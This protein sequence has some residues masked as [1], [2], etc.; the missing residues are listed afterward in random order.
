M[1]IGVYGG[2]GEG[3]D[4]FA[5][6]LMKHSSVKFENKKFAFKL[7]QI[8]ALLTGVD[9]HNFE[10]DD[11]KNKTI[12]GKWKHPRTSEPI[13]Y[14]F[15]LQYIGT[16][17][18]RDGLDINVW[19]NSL[20]ADYNATE[21]NFIITDMRF[22][23]EAQAIKDNGGITIKVSR[24]MTVSDWLSSSYFAGVFEQRG[25]DKVVETRVGKIVSKHEMVDI[26]RQYPDLIETAGNKAIFDKLTHP[27]EMELYDKGFEFDYYIDNDSTLESFEAKAIDFVKKILKD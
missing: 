18:F 27:S 5:S 16:E 19:V 1:I 3:K 13:T 2:I 7:K 14:R 20:F 26:V 12:P 24:Y 9:V 11:F 6:L 8:V 17:L 4:L 22:L 23:N 10:D 15:L 25:I 21:S